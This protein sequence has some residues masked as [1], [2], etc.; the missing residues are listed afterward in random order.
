MNKANQ[1]TSSSKIL[2]KH[3]NMHRLTREKKMKNQKKY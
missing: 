1:Y 2:N 3:Y